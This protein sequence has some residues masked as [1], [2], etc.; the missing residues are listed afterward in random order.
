[1]RKQIRVSG[2]ERRHSPEDN[3]LV[4]RVQSGR[5]CGQD[6]GYSSVTRRENTS[7]QC[8]APGSILRTRDRKHKPGGGAATDWGLHQGPHAQGQT[9]VLKRFQHYNFNR[10]FWVT[11]TTSFPVIHNR[12]SP[13]FISNISNVTISSLRGD[14][15][16]QRE[17]TL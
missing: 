5:R 15:P 6:G 2:Q 12:V 16:R 10:I 13:S 11:A 3:K 7:W 17:L 1:M 14:S 8:K 9:V 4:F